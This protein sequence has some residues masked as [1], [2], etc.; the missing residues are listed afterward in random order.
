L[1]FLLHWM[2]RVEPD[3][4]DSSQ[5]EPPRMNLAQ[6]PLPAQG[7]LTLEELLFRQACVQ[8]LRQIGGLPKTPPLS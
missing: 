6:R 7:E 1:Q 3:Q 4:P 8:R 2:S 5:L